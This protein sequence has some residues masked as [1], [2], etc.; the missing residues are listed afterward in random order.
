M[1]SSFVIF[2][3]LGIIAFQSFSQMNVSV[4]YKEETIYPLQLDTS[5]LNDNLL[6]LKTLFDKK[7]IIGM[8]E[9]THGT[10]EFFETKAKT[11][12]FLVTHCNYRVFGIEASYGE[13]NYINDYIKTGIG[14]IDSVIRLFGFWTWRTQEVKGLI[15]WIKNF[16]QSKSNS[17]KISFYGFDMQDFYSPLKYITDFLKLDSSTYKLEFDSI[18]HSILSKTEMQLYKKLQN[19]KMKFD[20]TLQLTFISLKSWITKNKISIEDKYQK[21]Q[22]VNFNFCID[23]FHQAIHMN[24]ALNISN[25]RDSCMAHNIVEIQ[26]NENAKMFI[27]AHNGHINLSYSENTSISMG[28]PMGAY[29]KNSIDSN[30]YAVGFIFNQGSF[31]AIKGPN[32]LMGVIFKYIFAKK[33]LYKGLME[34]TVPISKKNTFTNALSTTFQSPVF[35]DLSGTHN[36]IFTTS[37]KTY[38]IGAVY[39]NYKR[40]TAEINAQK[41][42]NSLI[43]IPK[44]ARATPIDAK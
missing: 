37:L 25:Y 9:A 32:T 4:D 13:C 27:W 2:L 36:A 38:D 30:Y 5:N 31:Q 14:N 42:F 33:H 24:K 21:K 39:L 12:Q 22:F 23:N 28:L 29:I 19:K 16:N 40:S 18:T 10:K 20:D 1:K 35:I 7:T 15:L 6:P 8:G 11:F 26:K 3:F 43:Y 17:E 44:T 41:Q 34:C